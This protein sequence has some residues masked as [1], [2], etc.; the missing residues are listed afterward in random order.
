V[1]KLLSLPFVVVCCAVLVTAAIDLWKFKIHN[2]VTLPLMLTGIAYHGITGGAAGAMESVLAA[3]F[4][5]TI[6][7]VLYFMGGM[8]GGDVKLL[9]AIGAWLLLPMTFWVFIASSIASGIYAVFLI[10][11]HKRYQQTWVN[12][13]I[14]YYRLTAI[15]R[16]LAA[17]DHVEVAVKKDDRR[18]RLIPF[19]PMV[20]LG[21][22][23]LLIVAWYLD[24]L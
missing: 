5:M 13:K 14:I 19:A 12:L 22:I 16:H 4:G 10:V 20:A 3:V 2:A 1:E 6:V 21:V 9:G 11:A 17:D 15:A 23:A 8:G 7:G 18:A 24:R